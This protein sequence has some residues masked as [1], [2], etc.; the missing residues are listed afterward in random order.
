MPSFRSRDR[1][2]NR[3]VYPIDEKSLEERNKA[4]AK[5]FLKAR[6]R[7]K[8]V[9]ITG[10]IPPQKVRPS[11]SPTGIGSL[12]TFLQERS[13]KY[14]EGKSKSARD[15]S[16]ASIVSEIDRLA[17]KS[18]IPQ[19]RKEELTATIREIKERKINHLNMMQIAIAEIASVGVSADDILAGSQNAADEIYLNLSRRA[20]Q[21]HRVKEDEI[22]TVRDVVIAL[23]DI[24]GGV[25]W[26][27]R[28]EKEQEATRLRKRRFDA[29]KKESS[30][31]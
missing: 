3:Q 21:E 11:I 24:P 22:F 26:K 19:A 30:Q 29:R 1:G 15:R 12:L 7:A 27:A 2:S 28:K 8:K 10:K 18:G 5:E 20:T 6:R 14:D 31:Q 4:M 17:D 16:F 13:T 23:S 9:Y 25:V